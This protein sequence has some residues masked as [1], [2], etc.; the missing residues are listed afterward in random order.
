VRGCEHVLATDLGRVCVCM[1]T[2][3]C[4]CA[5]SRFLYLCVC[6]LC[7]CACVCVC[8]LTA[9]DAPQGDGAGRADR[10]PPRQRARG[11]G[12]QRSE[13]EANTRVS[14]SCQKLITQADL[15][16]AASRLTVQEVAGAIHRA[17]A[18]APPRHSPRHA[19]SSASGSVTLRGGGD[20]AQAPAP[21]QAAAEAVAPAA[22]AVA[23][24][25]RPCR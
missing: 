23:A 15:N 7:R 10:H 13:V 16:G 2:R 6:E 17:P 18:R 20:G 24:S 14:L 8:V 25:R 12:G 19:A 5:L 22:P 1:R 4:A 9:G 3:V 21:A 11:C